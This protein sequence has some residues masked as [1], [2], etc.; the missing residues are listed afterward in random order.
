M[1]VCPCSGS[2]ERVILL[3]TVAVLKVKAKITMSYCPHSFFTQGYNTD[4][5][6]FN[7]HKKGAGSAQV[8]DEQEEESSR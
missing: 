1:T 2:A 8:V 3:K 7:D 5:L 6:H 4:Q